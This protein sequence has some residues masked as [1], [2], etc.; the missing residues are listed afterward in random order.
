MQKINVEQIM[1]EIREEIKQ[2]GYKSSDLNFDDIPVL[3]IVGMK[4]SYKV[5]S[6]KPYKDKGMKLLIKKI[7]RK[8]VWGSFSRNFKLQ[9]GFNASTLQTVSALV[10]MIETMQKRID[11][12]EEQLNGNR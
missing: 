6:Y 10:S 5:D 7:V 3:S 4:N 9:R 8:M 1:A 11:I 2:K 12:L